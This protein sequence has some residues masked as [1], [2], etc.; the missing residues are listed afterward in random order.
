M[1]NKATDAI[2]QAGLA[3]IN[4]RLSTPS[5]RFDSKVQPT[6]EFS[7]LYEQTDRWDDFVRRKPATTN[8]DN[9]TGNSRN[10]HGPFLRTAIGVCEAR[11]CL[12]KLIHMLIGRRDQPKYGASH[13][14]PIPCTLNATMLGR[15]ADPEFHTR[16]KCAQPDA[17]GH[18]Q[19]P[20][21]KPSCEVFL[22]PFRLS[23]R[24]HKSLYHHDGLLG[25]IAAQAPAS[26]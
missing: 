21:P 2:I 11:C 26:D 18:P 4:I 13:G 5:S 7:I 23:I 22:K 20:P 12:N 9:M 6:A 1:I 24:C 17:G 8:P 16:S 25:I 15:E 3:G 10:N 14:R 19:E